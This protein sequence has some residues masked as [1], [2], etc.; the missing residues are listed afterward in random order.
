MASR[1]R[2]LSPGREITVVAAVALL[3][4]WL[5]KTLLLQAFLIP[6]ESMEDT[7]RVGDRIVVNKLA[8]DQIR[9]G[10]I[11][12]FEDPGRWL[13]GSA[14][15]K[16]LLARATAQVGSFLSWLGLTATARDHLVKRVI[17]LPGDHIACRSGSGPV[18]LNGVP[19]QEPYLYPGDTG[20]AGSSQPFDVRVPPDSYWVMGDHRSASGDSRAHRQDPL[21]HGFLPQRRV[22]GRAF[23]VVWPVPHARKLERPA[24]FDRFA[25]Q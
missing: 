15:P 4:S 2:R 19:L 25:G 7:L 11:V 6:S 17:G 3:L 12:V 13:D 16:S 1:S 23:A 8:L 18:V 21:T 5:L 22:V 20:C 10:D 24:T 9:R 14:Q